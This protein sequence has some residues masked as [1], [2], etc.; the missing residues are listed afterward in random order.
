MLVVAIDN[1]V[2]A[3]ELVRYVR[4]NYPHVHVIVRAVD[5]HHVYELWSAGAR[6]I[7]RETFDSAV[8]TARSALEA[9]DVHPYDSEQQVRGFVENDKTAIRELAELYDPD[10]PV[11]LNAAYVTRTREIMAQVEKAMQAGS[12]IFGSRADRGWVP[13]TLRDVETAEAENVAEQSG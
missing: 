4:Q 5:R 11:H 10:I 12:A 9:L 8:R 2:R 3:T 1:R 7:I 6:D 13:P